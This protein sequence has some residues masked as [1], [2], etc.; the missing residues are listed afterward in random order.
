MKTHSDAGDAQQMRGP[1]CLSDEAIEEAAVCRITDRPLAADV[2]RHLSAC[3]HCFDR[4][5]AESNE[6]QSLR[7]ALSSL[8]FTV[9]EPCV[10]DEDIALYLDDALESSRRA[11]VEQH[12]ARCGSCQ[13]RMISLF[14][15]VRSVCAENTE[16]TPL[17]SVSL[18]EARERLAA[19]K[20]D[21]SDA[22]IDDEAI[23]PPSEENADV[24]LKREARQ[25]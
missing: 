21:Q 1:S 4:L 2:E 22:V 18:T 16:N 11:A 5:T 23:P 24:P 8:T 19:R 3:L 13:H 6:A 14:D 7:G 10:S 15:E 17:P 20:P 9:D 25:R 12:L